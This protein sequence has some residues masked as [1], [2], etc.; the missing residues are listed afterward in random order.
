MH[1]MMLRPLLTSSR[2]DPC[3]AVKHPQKDPYA[4]NVIPRRYHKH[5]W[6]ALNLY[7]HKT[8]YADIKTELIANNGSV[9]GIDCVPKVR[10]L[11]KPET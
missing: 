9:Q 2:D 10:I 3:I 7:K 4:F 11:L 5:H 1:P 6:F 8:I